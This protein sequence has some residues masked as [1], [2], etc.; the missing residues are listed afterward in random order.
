MTGSTRHLSKVGIVILNWNGFEDTVECLASI[1]A[2]DYP[3]FEII[4]VDNGSSDGSGEAIS[5]RYP[6]VKIIKNEKNL[7]YTGGNNVGIINALKSG[8]EYVWLLNNDTTVE[9]DTLS[10]LVK[11]FEDNPQNGILSPI[12]YE[13]VNPQEVQ[14]CGCYAD[15]KSF[16]FRSISNLKKIRLIGLDKLTYIWGTALLVRKEVF[17]RVG[18]L[19]EKYF[20]YFEDYEFSNRASKAGFKCRIE[21]SAKIYHKESRST[22]SK[23]APLQIYLRVRNEHFVWS[24]LVK[25]I[26][27]LRYY[28]LFLAKTVTAAAKLKEDKLYDSFEACLDGAWAGLLGVGGSMDNRSHMPKIIRSLLMWHPWMLARLAKLEIFPL[29]SFSS[30]SKNHIKENL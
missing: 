24:K 20:A 25:G 7:G 6:H 18:L 3:N 29:Y 2:I 28:R 1:V 22:G 23:K 8:S 19:N 30:N 5:R 15:L 12:I 10:K 4:V 21:T 16:Q 14:Y 17:E 9:T 27:L 26:K 13:Y 11:N